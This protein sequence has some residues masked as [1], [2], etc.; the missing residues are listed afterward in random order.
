MKRKRR[1]R[2]ERESPL[3]P[4]KKGI[5][6]RVFSPLVAECFSYFLKRPAVPICGDKRAS[7]CSFSLR[8]HPPGSRPPNAAPEYG[9]PIHSAR[10]GERNTAARAE[11]GVYREL[12]ATVFRCA[13]YF[14]K[15]V[16]ETE[17]EANTMRHTPLLRGLAAGNGNAHLA[18]RLYP[19]SFLPRI[20]PFKLLFPKDQAHLITGNRLLF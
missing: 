4:A 6:S 3:I 2:H 1:D 20:E 11:H 8:E 13:V 15:F 7:F 12:S 5:F 16:E 19:D 14:V 17:L 9:E 18:C 10:T